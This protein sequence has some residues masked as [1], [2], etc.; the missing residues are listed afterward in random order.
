MTSKEIRQAFLDFFTSKQHEIVRSAPVIPADDPTLLFTNAGMNQFKDV[1]LGIGSRPYTRA[2]DTQKCIRASGK[3]NDLED[4]GRDTYHHTFFEMLG[5]WS[6]GDYYKKEAITWAWELLTDVWKLP[7]DRLY[8]TVYKDDDEAFE[9]W[10]S[11]TDIA[12]SHIQRHG[13]KDNFW[14]MGET[15]PCGPCSEIHIDLTPDKSGA[16][17]VNAGRPEVIEIWNL[18]FIQYNRDAAGKLHPLPAKHVD[19]GMGFERIAA[20]LQGKTSNYDS[21]VFTPILKKIGDITGKTYGGSMESDTDMAMRVLADH[22]RTL[23]FA[24][25]DGGT[26]SNEGRGYVLRRILRRGVRYARQLGQNEP[27]LYKLT[28]VLCETMGDVFPEL[29]ERRQ[30]IEQVIKAEEESFLQTL[31]R[32]I[33]IFNGVTEKLKK[34]GGKVIDGADAFKLYDTY[35][36]PLDLTRLMAEEIGLSV[37][38]DGFLANMKEQKDR[39]R[40]DRKEKSAVAE[41]SGEWTIFAE[42]LKTEF[43]GY[44]TLEQKSRI[45]RAKK[46]GEKLLLVLEKTPF[47]AESGGQQGDSGEIET[48]AF[49]FHISDTQ[50]EGDLVLHIVDKITDKESGD[51]VAIENFDLEKLSSLEADAKVNAET[52]GATARNHTATHLLHEALREVL[53]EHVQQ[54]GSLVGPERLRFDFSHF[55][56]VSEEAMAQIEQIVNAQIRMAKAV[57]KHADVPFEDAKKMGA[58]AFFGDKYGDFVRVVEVPGYSVEFCGGT[59]LDNIG[60]IGLLKIVSESSIASGIRRVEAVTGKVAEDLFRSDRRKLQALRDTLSAQSEDAV[61][62]RVQKILEEKKELEKEVEKLRLEL[63]ASALDGLVKNAETLN[64]VKILAAEVKVSGADELKQLGEMA[65]S[66]LGSGVLLLGAALGEK[67]SLVAAVSDDVIKSHKLQAGKLVGEVAKVVKGGGGG[68]PN[69]ATA[70]GKDP[71]KL[72]EAIEKFKEIVTAALA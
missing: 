45:A 24:I 55:E 18:V 52:R 48:D 22:I 23:A 62:E 67:A 8:A 65:R 21:D 14:E 13:E 43:S 32:G 42:T 58:L 26:P 36:F 15:G 7:K 72:S 33:E 6:F 51:A 44:E 4:V 12:A 41:E 17:L 19:T 27:T 38:E 50:K 20:V 63:A 25:A 28:E 64:G 9:L 31:D 60:E 39:A 59:H 69:L 5:N 47:Y 61:L 70:G 53:G 56:R 37:D 1:F 10:K 40:K 30:V 11:E 29:V 35:G 49:S 46:A 71:Q 2:A 16:A 57:K 66:K 54:K 3:H 34:S 68:R